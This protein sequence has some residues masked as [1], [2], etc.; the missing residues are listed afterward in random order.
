LD[1]SELITKTER[2]KLTDVFT[3]QSL[4]S[5]SEILNI[6]IEPCGVRAYQIY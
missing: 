4:D 5:E 1:L 2:L 6:V 3:E